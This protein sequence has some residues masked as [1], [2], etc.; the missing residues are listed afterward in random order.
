MG[1]SDHETTSSPRGAQAVGPGAS[2]DCAFVKKDASALGARPRSRRTSFTFS[3]SMP[4]ASG[5][6]VTMREPG[7]I[8]AKT[9]ATCSSRDRS[10]CL[11]DRAPKISL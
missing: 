3:A 7:F 4:S 8:Q 6:N 5:W 10:P 9:R 11:Q 2:V 1:P